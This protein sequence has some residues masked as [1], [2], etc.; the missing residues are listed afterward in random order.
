MDFAYDFIIKNGGIDTEKDYPYLAA[1]GVC[2]KAKLHRHVVTIDGFQ[3][4]PP[5][6]ED[7]LMKVHFCIHGSNIW[8]DK[9]GGLL[10]RPLYIG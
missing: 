7:A 8:M 3:D 9:N 5:N 4:V 1:D 6:N 2:A 10:V